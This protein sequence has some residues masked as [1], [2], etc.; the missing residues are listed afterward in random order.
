MREIKVDGEFESFEGRRFRV[1]L[2][3]GNHVLIPCA[4]D[5]IVEELNSD[6]EWVTLPRVKSIKIELS[7]K[8]NG[9]PTIELV[10][11]DVGNSHD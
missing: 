1:R 10:I 9:P 2:K 7:A 11:T 8:D 6:D 4:R 3:P 5:Y